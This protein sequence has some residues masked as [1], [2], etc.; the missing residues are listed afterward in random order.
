MKL[1]KV[2]I[3]IIIIIGIDYND[4]IKWRIR[5]LWNGKLFY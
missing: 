1:N 4:E 5:K 2:K 3:I